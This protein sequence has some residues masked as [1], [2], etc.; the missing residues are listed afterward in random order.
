MDRRVFTEEN[1]YEDDL[2]DIDFGNYKGIFYE[3]D[4]TTKYQDPETGAHFDFDDICNRLTQ[5]KISRQNWVDDE[6]GA[7]LSAKD[8]LR[9][10]LGRSIKD[11]RQKANKNPKVEP[12]YSDDEDEEMSVVDERYPVDK[13]NVNESNFDAEYS[14]DENQQE[15]LEKLTKGLEF[16]NKF[17]DYK[18]E[19]P[20]M[21][22]HRRN[23]DNGVNNHLHFLHKIHQTEEDQEHV[24]LVDADFELN[25]FCNFNEDKANLLEA[26]NAK[27]TKNLSILIQLSYSLIS[28][29]Y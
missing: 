22:F 2:D 13:E 19:H 11:T 9:M 17:I 6:E 25:E 10:K 28:S 7:E 5:I 15:D 23:H 4:P 1:E 16:K 8:K 12:E 26:L 21:L 20:D 14:N 27:V 29:I 3:D 18:G 24:E